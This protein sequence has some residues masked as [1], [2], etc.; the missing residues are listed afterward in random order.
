M[1]TARSC[2]RSRPVSRLR[3]RRSPSTGWTA[4]N[5]TQSSMRSCTS[6][7]ATQRPSTIGATSGCSRVSPSTFPGCT[8]PTH[9]TSTSRPEWRSYTRKYVTRMQDRPKALKSM[10]CST[11]TPC[12]PRCPG[13]ARAS[14]PC[15]GRRV[16]R[17]LANPLRGRGREC[18]QYNG[19]P[20]YRR[21]L[22]GQDA[23]ALVESWLFDPDVP[24]A[25][26]TGRPI[27]VGS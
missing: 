21:R 11:I 13:L 27:P 8:W 22:A 25:L 18:H 24:E 3:T 2:C 17:Y 4:S 23:A 12:M 26:P 19:L 9:T 20:R 7:S 14:P 15:R 1:P 10:S 5:R 6:G 16:L